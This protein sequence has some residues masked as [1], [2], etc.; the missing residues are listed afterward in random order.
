MGKGVSKNIS[1]LQEG[2]VERHGQSRLSLRV[3]AE[4]FCCAEAAAW[5]LGRLIRRARSAN[6]RGSRTCGRTSFAR[7]ARTSVASWRA[8]REGRE[9]GRPS[10]GVEQSVDD[11]G[12]AAFHLRTGIVQTGARLDQAALHVEHLLIMKVAERVLRLEA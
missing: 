12:G 4:S 7:F 10:S 11:L 1:Y 3:E 6:R 9:G 8:E 5:R 2:Q